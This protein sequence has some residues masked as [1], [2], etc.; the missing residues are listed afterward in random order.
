MVASL[1]ARTFFLQHF[2]YITNCT[3]MQIITKLYS[4]NLFVL[5]SPLC[6]CILTFNYAE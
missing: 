5:F 6:C 1:L 4:D 2:S 3:E